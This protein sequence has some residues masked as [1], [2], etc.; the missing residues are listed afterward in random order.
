MVIGNQ[1]SNRHH[2]SRWHFN[3][4]VS[5]WMLASCDPQ[6]SS[7]FLNS[8]RDRPGRLGRRGEP[9]AIILDSNSN[10]PVTLLRVNQGVARASVAQRVAHSLQHDLDDLLNEETVGRESG[11]DPKARI[12]YDREGAA[13]SLIEIRERAHVGT[14]LVELARYP[15]L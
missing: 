1:Q 6:A 2:L 14:H 5:T 3:F 9:D 12:R 11:F 4:Q 7:A 13:Q 8:R 15:S 10:E